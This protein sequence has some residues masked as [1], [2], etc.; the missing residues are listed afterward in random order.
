MRLC[1][2]KTNSHLMM[3][4]LEV[5]IYTS[6]YL[7]YRSSDVCH[8]VSFYELLEKRQI[9]IPI[10]VEVYSK[11]QDYNLSNTSYKGKL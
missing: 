4:F 9:I 8:Y 7:H 1:C 10:H 5:Y 2:H 11:S 6:L 3:A